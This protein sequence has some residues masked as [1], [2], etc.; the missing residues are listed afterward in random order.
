V[1]TAG[2][3]REAAKRLEEF[4]I[5][6][7]PDAIEVRSYRERKATRDSIRDFLRR[8]EIERIG[9]GL[10]RYIGREERPTY[11]QRLWDI[12]RRMIRFNLNDLEQIT[13]AR[14][15]TVKEFCSWM[16]RKEYAQRVKPGHFKAI[17]RL[18]PIVPKY[19]KRN[20]QCDENGKAQE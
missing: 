14:R 10:Y 16:V 12:A 18:S 5:R 3:I 9:Y 20:A 15:D 19:N 17:G 13:E 2:R 1:T 8:G 11:R 6:E 7:I 4:Q